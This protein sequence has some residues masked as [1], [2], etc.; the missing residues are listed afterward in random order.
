MR[1]EEKNRIFVGSFV[2]F[3][4]LCSGARSTSSFLFFLRSTRGSRN[5]SLSRKGAREGGVGKVG[6]GEPRACSLK[7]TTTTTPGWT[8]ARDAF[9]FR[10]CQGNKKKRDEDRE[11]EAI[12][13]F[14]PPFPR[15]SSCPITLSCSQALRLEQINPQI[16]KKEKENSLRVSRPRGRFLA[17][18]REQQRQQ[19]R[20]CRLRRRQR[21]ARQPAFSSSSAR[22]RAWT[23]SAP[24][25]LPTSRRQRAPSGTRRRSTGPAATP[26]PAA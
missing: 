5:R 13:L 16:S 24:P 22:A 25:R 10:L 19:R 2:V 15:R 6:K 21:R 23:T 20:L 7:K 11:R 12:S 18:L 1:N 17:C 8:P 3:F 26:R 4:F 14:L 9:F